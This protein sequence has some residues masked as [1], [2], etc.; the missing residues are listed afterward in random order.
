MKT[1]ILIKVKTLQAQNPPQGK[2]CY[3]KLLWICI[4]TYTHTASSYMLT[5]YVPV[6]L[7]LSSYYRLCL[8]SFMW[9]VLQTT[10]TCK[11][12]LWPLQELHEDFEVIS[13]FSMNNIQYTYICGQSRWLD[14]IKN[15]SRIFIVEVAKTI[16]ISSSLIFIFAAVFTSGDWVKFWILY[17][18]GLRLRWSQNFFWR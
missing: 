16:G 5:N 13:L 7:T 15:L 8:V 17:V 4:T 18:K 10:I 12:I 6:L 9:S 11:P 3:K 2:F 14:Q 1:K